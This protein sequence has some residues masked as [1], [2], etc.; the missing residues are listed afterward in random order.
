MVQLVFITCWNPEEGGSRARG[1]GF[2]MDL[3]ERLR[4]SRQRVKLPSSISSN[5]LPEESMA[6]IKG[7][8]AHLNDL[9]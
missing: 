4:A 7:V 1:F 2:R 8:S 6:Q 3:L 9:D 5:S